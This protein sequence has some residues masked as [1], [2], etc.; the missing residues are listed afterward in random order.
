MR[1]HGSAVIGRDVY[2]RPGNRGH[3]DGAQDLLNGPHPRV[4][5]GRELTP[6]RRNDDGRRVHTCSD[7]YLSTAVRGAIITLPSPYRQEKPASGWSFG[8]IEK[9]VKRH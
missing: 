7:T 8:R 2:V 4:E 5:R 9:G 1:L 6:R 3:T